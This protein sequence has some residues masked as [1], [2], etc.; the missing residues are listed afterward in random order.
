MTPSIRFDQHGSVIGQYLWQRYPHTATL[1]R[2]ANARL[3]QATTLRPSAG[4]HYPWA[5]VARATALRLRYSA[6]NTPPRALLALDGAARLAQAHT[7][8][9]SLAFVAALFADLGARLARLTPTGGRR[10]PAEDEEHLCRICYL[11]GLCEDIARTGR[12]IQS[13]LLDPAV[14]RT[15]EG[16]LA[17][18]DPVCVADIAAMAARFTA[19]HGALL[20]Q[21]ATLWP[22]LGGITP[23]GRSLDPLILGDGLYLIKVT[24]QPQIEARWLRELLGYLLLDVYDRYGVRQVGIIAPR[25]GEVLRWP[26]SFAATLAGMPASAFAASLPALRR[27]FAALRRV[28]ASP[29]MPLVTAG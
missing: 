20:A 8:P 15:V 16:L 11:L 6:G 10:M 23:A 17:L 1:A 27:E 24:A 21:P 25:Q 4:E 3:A 7:A 18:A 13:P 19:A 22:A 29:A 12:L 14:P 2:A 28:M 26:A 5:V 9:Y